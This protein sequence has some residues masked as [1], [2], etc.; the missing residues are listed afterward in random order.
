VADDDPRGLRNL[1]CRLGLFDLPLFAAGDID[2]KPVFA[3]APPVLV[4]QASARVGN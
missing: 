2:G 4:A 1:F 3:P